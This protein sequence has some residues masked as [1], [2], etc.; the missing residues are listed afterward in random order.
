MH[1]ERIK[2]I[3]AHAYTM[4][5]ITTKDLSSNLQIIGEVCEVGVALNFI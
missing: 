1:K 3:V 4:R 5:F 2:R